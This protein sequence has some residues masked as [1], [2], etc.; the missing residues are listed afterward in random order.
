MLKTTIPMLMRKG[1]KRMFCY[2][3]TPHGV[4][5][6]KIHIGLSDDGRTI[7]QVTFEGGCNGNLKAIG[8]LVAGRQVD[9]VVSLLAGNTCG[10][11]HTSCADQMA[12]ALRQAQEKTSI[13]PQ[14]K[15]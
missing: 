5:S 12:R 3:F 11:R 1:F 4:C 2:E 15:R 13:Q 8:K 14:I 9:E 7:E 6:R 10:Q